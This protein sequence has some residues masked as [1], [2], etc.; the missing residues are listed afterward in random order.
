MSTSHSSFRLSRPNRSGVG[1][2]VVLIAGSVLGLAVFGNPSCST[3]PNAQNRPA[4]PAT[5]PPPQPAPTPPTAER[6]ASP[7]GPTG[8]SPS[9][10][11]TYPFKLVTI[12]SEPADFGGTRCGLTV[13]GDGWHKS[14][15]DGV[16]NAAL[17]R[18]WPGSD[19]LPPNEVSCLLESDNAS[20]IQRVELEAEFYQPGLHESEMLLQFAQSAQVLMHPA[21]PPNEFAEAVSEKGEWSNDQWELTRVPYANGGFGLLLRRKAR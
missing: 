1:C 6:S 20:T 18:Q 14:K 5:Q 11:K 4:Q 13:E 21:A 17:R 16:W 8:Y 9:D 15:A 2:L 19:R 3:S 7:S 10:D 12:L